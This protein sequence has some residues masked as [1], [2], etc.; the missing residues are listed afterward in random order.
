MTEAVFRVFLVLWLVC[1]WCVAGVLVT[2]CWI[3]IKATVH[4]SFKNESLEPA[5]D[6][7]T[8]LPGVTFSSSG[9]DFGQFGPRNSEETDM[10]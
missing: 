8:V 3:W 4:C 5:E 9:E 6:G 7:M 1:C 2:G 10:K